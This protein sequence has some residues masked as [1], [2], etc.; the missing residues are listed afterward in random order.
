MVQNQDLSLSS[1]P[2]NS[3]SKLVSLNSYLRDFGVC[4][5]LQF[6]EILFK[7]WST[8][9]RTS[10]TAQTREI[11]PEEEEEEDNPNKG[12]IYTDGWREIKIKVVMKANLL[13]AYYL[14]WWWSWQLKK[15][16]CNFFSISFLITTMLFLSSPKKRIPMI[17]KNH[18]EI[19]I[20][21]LN[22]VPFS[23]Q[24]T[25]LIHWILYYALFSWSCIL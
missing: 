19:F 1:A 7:W 21:L 23:F 14:L 3:I 12:E 2:I 11:N 8:E 18:G 13:L 4:F 15:M 24:I 25:I 6:I 5:D 22:S 20:L 9:W 16:F 17:N 10:L